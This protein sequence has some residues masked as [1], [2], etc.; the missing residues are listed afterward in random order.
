MVTLSYYCHCLGQPRSISQ[1]I[2]A[3]GMRTH[4][5][6]LVQINFSQ[7]QPYSKT[8]RTSPLNK[9]NILSECELQEVPAMDF[10]KLILVLHL[11]TTYIWYVRSNTTCRY[12]N[13]VETG[14]LIYIRTLCKW[15]ISAYELIFLKLQMDQRDHIP[16]V[17]GIRA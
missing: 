10:I 4:Q 3:P 2:A 1:C 16:K 8:D 14:K 9:I 12:L 13:P 7:T 15:N 11:F 6:H 5:K 17:W